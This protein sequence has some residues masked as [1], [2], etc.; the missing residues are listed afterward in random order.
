LDAEL[1]AGMAL[2]NYANDLD[3]DEYLEN[4]EIQEALRA[5]QDKVDACDS[6]EDDEDAERRKV[7]EEVDRGG[8]SPA[9]SSCVSSLPAISQRKAL[10]RN[11]NP[12]PTPLS[13]VSHDKDWD[14]ST[15]KKRLISEAALRTAEEV[16]EKHPHMRNVHSKLSLAKV[17]EELTKRNMKAEAVPKDGAE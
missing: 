12:A 11:L 7:I 13:T 4:Y 5:I 14:I 2:V 8:Y 10:A 17:L 3:I 6:D 15:Q 1:A 16:L 9:A